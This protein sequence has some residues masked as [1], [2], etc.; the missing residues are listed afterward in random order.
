MFLHLLAQFSRFLI[1]RIF[2]ELDN[3]D[4]SFIYFISPPP[5]T[6]PILNVLSICDRDHAITPDEW[7]RLQDVNVADTEDR[8]RAR[9]LPRRLVV[10]SVLR[11]TSIYWSPDGDRAALLME[12]SVQNNVLSCVTLPVIN[13]CCQ[14]QQTSPV[15]PL[16]D[17]NGHCTSVVKASWRC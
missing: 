9:W 12:A 3:T 1:S 7:W 4:D 6:V 11:H 5:Y 17:F 2:P 13:H 16:G 14:A 8:N 15:L 10:C